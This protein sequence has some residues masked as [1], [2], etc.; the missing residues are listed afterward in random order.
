MVGVFSILV[1]QKNEV[2]MRTAL[3]LANKLTP[4]AIGIEVGT[5]MGDNAIDILTNWNGT[6]SLY[7]IDNFYMNYGV[8]SSESTAEHKEI[9]I[10]RMKK[11]PNA[12]LI[13]KSS[14]EAV[15]EFQ[16][17]SLDFVYID[18]DHRMASVIND[19]QLWYPKVK[20]GG[21]LCGHD[22]NLAE[23]PVM[24]AVLQFAVNNKLMLKYDFTSLN[25]MGIISDWWII[26]GGGNE[27]H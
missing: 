26:K 15:Q 6:L 2:G 19:C 4:N 25:Y 11:Y 22:Y 7:L 23:P 12:T 24:S 20:I 5:G 21:L 8:N 9:C 13:I 3:T 18:A 14:T 17:N 16:D 10:E 27:N 1:L